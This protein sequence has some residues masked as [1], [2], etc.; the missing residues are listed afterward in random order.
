MI[1][2]AIAIYVA[3]WSPTVW[4][5][6]GMLVVFQIVSNLFFYVNSYAAVSASSATRW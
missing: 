6:G 2:F 4:G 3:A 5:G 1:V